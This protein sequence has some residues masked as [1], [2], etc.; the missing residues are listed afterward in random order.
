M[1]TF[2]KAIC[3]AVYVLAVL[4]AFVALPFGIAPALQYLA[5]ILLVLHALEALIALRSVRRYPG[6]LVDSIALTL[7]FGFLHWKPLTGRA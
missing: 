3:L 6:P 2:A 4:G 5:V 1:I 7:L